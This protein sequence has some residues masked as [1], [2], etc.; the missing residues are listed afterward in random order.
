MNTTVEQNSIQNTIVMQRSVF[1]MSDETMAAFH[2]WSV[3]KLRQE[4]ALCAKRMKDQGMAEALIKMQL[5]I[6][7]QTLS[8]ALSQLPAQCDTAALASQ[9][10]MLT[11]TLNETRS[12]LNACEDEIAR[13]RSERHDSWR[14]PSAPHTPNS[15]DRCAQRVSSD[16]HTDAYAYD[17]CG[18]WRSGY[19]PSW[20][21]R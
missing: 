11:A 20:S 6:D 15:H 21:P 4:I 2:G 7:D 14:R 5:R 12:R 16:S 1:Q 9:V 13:L 3:E 18:T 8:A 19:Q 10:A 17:D